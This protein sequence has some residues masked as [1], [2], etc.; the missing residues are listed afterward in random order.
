MSPGSPAGGVRTDPRLP[1]F[2]IPGAGKSGTSS[3]FAWLV[4]HPDVGGAR[5][6]E[7]GFFTRE[8]GWKDGGGEEAATQSGR[9][10]L[11]LDWYLEL[12]DGTEGAVAR[13]EASTLYMPAGDTPELIREVAPEVT[14]ILLL[15]DPVARLHSHY[16]Q[17]SKHG[18]DL[19]PFDELVRGDH[20]RFRRYARVS[21]YEEHLERYLGRFPAERVHVLLYEDLVADPQALV[22]RAYEAIGVDAAFVPPSIGRQHNAATAPRF[23]RLE[24]LLSAPLGRWGARQ[25]P[26]WI[27][28]PAGRLRRR[29]SRFN[30]RRARYEPMAPELRRELVGR[31]EPTIAW[32]ERHL[33]RPLPEWRRVE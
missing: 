2:L 27:R 25:I 13:G 23:R 3:L 11:G 12:F 7:P 30:R 5:I 24:R 31:F 8:P 22:A 10:D 21:R 33:D 18:W 17:E 19:P 9:F 29:L 1:T 14:L 4:E 16:F 28:R 20:P 32:V 6:K 26:A 15:R